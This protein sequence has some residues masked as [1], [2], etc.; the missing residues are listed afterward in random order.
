MTNEAAA[1]HQS[2]CANQTDY[3]DHLQPQPDSPERAALVA[4]QIEDNA[5]QS[6]HQYSDGKPYLP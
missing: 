3:S 1:K 4:C 6:Q 2:K 5:N